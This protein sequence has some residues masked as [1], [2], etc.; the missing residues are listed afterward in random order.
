[1]ISHDLNDA[2]KY[3][4]HILHVGSEIFFGTKAEYLNS[5]L[6]KQFTSEIRNNIICENCGRKML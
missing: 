3:A 2:L 1:M 5:E 6:G 4:T